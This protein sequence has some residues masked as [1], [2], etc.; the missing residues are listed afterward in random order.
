MRDSTLTIEYDTV[1][2]VIYLLVGVV[3]GVLPVVMLIG[4]V[5]LAVQPVRRGAISIRISGSRRLSSHEF[6]S[7]C[8]SLSVQSIK[9]YHVVHPFYYH[10]PHRA[11]F[12]CQ[13]TVHLITEYQVPALTS[14]YLSIVDVVVTYS[15]RSQ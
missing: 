7:P 12:D 15:S 9:I 11:I 2:L 3:V 5:V 6:I 4:L 8:L 14:F 10:V 13:G 1:W